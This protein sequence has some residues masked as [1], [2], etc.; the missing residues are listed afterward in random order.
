[1]IAAPTAPPAIVIASSTAMSAAPSTLAEPCSTA[2]S[3]GWL[4]RRNRLCGN[5][6]AEQRCRIHRNFNDDEFAVATHPQHR[7][8]GGAG[9][10]RPGR[11]LVVAPSGQPGRFP[12]RIQTTQLRPD[13]G[14]PPGAQHRHD[15]QGGQGECGFDGTGADLTGQTLV[16]SARLMMAVSAPTIE[17]PVT[18]V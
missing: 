2:G 8:A 3:G 16:F 1:M 10:Y 13:R 7:A 4:D 14:E 6:E 11:S 17:S 5:G 15:Q 18:T 12:C 9:A